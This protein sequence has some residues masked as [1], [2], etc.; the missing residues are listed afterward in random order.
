MYTRVNKPRKRVCDMFL[1]GDDTFFPSNTKSFFSSRF[2]R[3]T[4]AY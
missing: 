4:P 1:H 3:D 2:Y